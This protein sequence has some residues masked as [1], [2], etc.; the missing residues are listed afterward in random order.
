MTI[1]DSAEKWK[2]LCAEA[3]RKQ[4]VGVEIPGDVDET[5]CGTVCALAT[6]MRGPGTCI[7]S[8]VFVLRVASQAVFNCAAALLPAIHDHFS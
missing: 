6:G 7:F 5:G 4:R 1:N 2:V 8:L 3:S